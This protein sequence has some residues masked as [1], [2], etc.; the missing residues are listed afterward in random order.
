METTHLLTEKPLVLFPGYVARIFAGE[1]KILR[2]GDFLS[3]PGDVVHSAVA[4][5]ET[6][7]YEIFTPVREDLIARY[8]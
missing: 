7:L 2:S 5:V 3:I 8:V 1:K 6:E 4:L